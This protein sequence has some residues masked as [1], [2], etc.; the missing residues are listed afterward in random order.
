MRNAKQ[1]ATRSRRTGVLAVALLASTVLAA[2]NGGGTE[3]AGDV[4]KN[5]KGG[6]EVAM[7]LIAYKP[8][9]LEVTPV[10]EVTWT[11]KDA[12]FHTV[13]SG[14]VEQGPAGVTPKPDGKFDSGEIPTGETYVF[15]FEEPGTYPYFCGV[16]PATMR[17]EVSVR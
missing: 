1:G 13:T 10:T 5:G 8:D 14:A 2:C 3:S 16:H 7:E 15:T 11:Q 17:G 12:G 4:G 6:A 9:R